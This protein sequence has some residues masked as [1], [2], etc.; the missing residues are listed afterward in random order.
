M[1]KRIAIAALAVAGMASSALA[2]APDG[3][4]APSAA[5][6]VAIGYAPGSPFGGSHGAFD[7]VWAGVYDT[8]A[9]LAGYD[10]GWILTA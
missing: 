2:M 10:M 6:T 5:L 7:S 9:A 3:R 1:K 4:D 8:G